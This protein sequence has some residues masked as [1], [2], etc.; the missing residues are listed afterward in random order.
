[1]TLNE[2][3]KKFA[4]EFDETPMSDFTADT[5]YRQLDEWSSLSGLS[6]ISMIDKEFDKQITGAD[7][8]SVLTIE[9]LY[10]LVKS[11]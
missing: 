3:I 8:R 1:M 2:F 5:K 6:I 4:E 7:L 10:N 9:E 11:K